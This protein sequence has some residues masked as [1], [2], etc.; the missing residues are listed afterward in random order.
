V[1][2]GVMVSAADGLHPPEGGGLVG[3]GEGPA[4]EAGALHPQLDLGSVAQ[5]G[6]GLGLVGAG[7]CGFV[8]HEGRP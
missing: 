4:Q 1:V 6:G 7:G 8:F 2:G 3:G 5:G